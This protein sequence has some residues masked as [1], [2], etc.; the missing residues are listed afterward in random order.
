MRESSQK[1]YDA[2]TAE[3]GGRRKTREQRQLLR[4][5]A[6]DYYNDYF[7]VPILPQITLVGHLTAAGLPRLIEQVKTGAFDSGEAEAAEW[8]ASEEGKR[9]FQTIGLTAERFGH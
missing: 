4:R 5:I 8:A 6:R 7:G 1:L 3:L 2:V 9:A